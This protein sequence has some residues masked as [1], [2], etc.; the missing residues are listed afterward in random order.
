MRLTANS[1]YR[2]EKS[3]LSTAPRHV[4]FEIPFPGEWCLQDRLWRAQ[5]QARR[6]NATRLL[7]PFAEGLARAGDL[8]TLT[9]LPDISDALPWFDWGPVGPAGLPRVMLNVIEFAYRCGPAARRIL[10]TSSTRQAVARFKRELRAAGFALHR[11]M[12]DILETSPCEAWQTKLATPIHEA[13][14][15]IDRARERLRAEIAAEAE[16]DRRKAAVY[17]TCGVLAEDLNTDREF[18]RHALLEWGW[19]TRITAIPLPLGDVA[20]IKL[21]CHPRWGPRYKESVL[22]EHMGCRIRRCKYCRRWYAASPTKQRYCLRCWRKGAQAQWRSP[23]RGMG[24]HSSTAGGASPKSRPL[25]ASQH[26]R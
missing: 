17:A 18:L 22:F 1:I 19:Q 13:R 12:L 8:K 2:S 6:E 4:V 24:V 11:E 26:V 15:A 20:L 21:L 3:V 14:G 5:H 25:R 16:R 10:L 7:A 9:G 23:K